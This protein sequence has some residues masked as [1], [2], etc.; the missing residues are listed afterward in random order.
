MI[1]YLKSKSVWNQLLGPVAI[2]LALFGVD[3]PE[4]TREGLAVGLAA[5]FGIA[6]IIIRRFTDKPLSE[7]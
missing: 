1:Q 5:V 6:G 3:V 2:A 7:K 4:E